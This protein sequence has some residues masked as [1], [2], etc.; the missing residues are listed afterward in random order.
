LLNLYKFSAAKIQLFIG[1]AN[2]EAAIFPY[3]AAPHGYVALCID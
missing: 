1:H 2:L 3:S